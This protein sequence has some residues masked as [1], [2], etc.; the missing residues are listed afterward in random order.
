MNGKILMANESACEL[1][2]YDSL[3]GMNFRDIAPPPYQKL[4]KPE[5]MEKGYGSVLRQF[6]RKDG[7]LV[8]MT[9]Q[10]TVLKDEQGELWGV[11][12]YMYDSTTERELRAEVDHLSNKLKDLLHSIQQALNKKRA[13]PPEVTTAE[14]EIAAL[15]KQGLS[16]RDIAAMRKIGAKSVENT[17]VSL[18][19]KLG[20][21]R[22]TSLQVCKNMVIFRVA[23]PSR[24]LPPPPPKI[25]VGTKKGR[26]SKRLCMFH[27]NFRMDTAF[28]FI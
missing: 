28:Q 23:A 9:A 22:R 8:R 27:L 14:R 6:L 10:G 5:H 1:M 4:F 7:S 18:R 24:G 2:G 19:R 13:L 26:A 21:D 16:S 3:E 17:R 25:V 15:V 20:I 12:I 11:Y